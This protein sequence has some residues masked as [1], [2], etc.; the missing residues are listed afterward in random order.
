MT[1][2]AEYF[3]RADDSDD[4]L[5]YRFPRRVVHIDDHAIA[6]LGKLFLELLPTGGEYLDLM[7]S[8]RSHIPTALAPRLVAGLGMNDEEMAD[9]PALNEYVVQNLNLQPALPYPDARFD[10]V[11]CTVSVQY[12]T[13]PI[14]VFREVYRVL[15]P[16][17][18][19]IVSFSNRCFPTKAV[20]VWRGTSDRQH[21]ALVAQYFELSA[22]WSDLDARYET[23]PNADPLYAVW[24]RKRADEKA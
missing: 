11:L 13:R 18:V 19:F 16:G 3:G 9:N 6:V 5:F 22:A 1:F 20:A 21:M 2:P 12:L 8:W 23:A 14:D 10:A 15:K 24:A 7:S 4:G 17:G